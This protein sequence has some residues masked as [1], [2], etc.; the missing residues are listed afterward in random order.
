MEST[1]DYF[2]GL[3]TGKKRESQPTRPENEVNTTKTHD[4]NENLC[5]ICFDV[6]KPIDSVKLNCQ[7]K[8]QF[9][10]EC[11]ET[12]AVSHPTCPFDREKLSLNDLIP[13]FGT[14]NSIR[15]YTTLVLRGVIRGAQAYLLISKIILQP[16]FAF[17][18]CLKYCV[19]DLI[20][21]Y[22]L[23]RG[24]LMSN[25]LKRIL[26]AP[27]SLVLEFEIFHVCGQQP[28]QILTNMNYYQITQIGTELALQSLAPLNFGYNYRLV[29]AC[30]PNKKL[31]YFGFVLGF[32]AVGYPFAQTLV[33][34]C[35]T[36]ATK[37][38]Q[39][40]GIYSNQ[41]LKYINL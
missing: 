4:D 26:S 27:L 25:K 35:T 21:S 32:L 37:T 28:V 17:R 30:K 29:S 33:N 22:I 39:C 19:T 14:F 24:N 7:G 13:T 36:L 23:S 1:I 40:Y 16:T 41:V 18:L 34:F 5:G 11:I 38:T 31:F 3:F 6:M 15:Y 12:W 9:H 8:H 20:S 2:V 10:V